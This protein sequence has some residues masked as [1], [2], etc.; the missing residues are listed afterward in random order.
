LAG[1][2]AVPGV[3]HPDVGGIRGVDSIPGTAICDDHITPDQTVGV[4]IVAAAAAGAPDVVVI[5]ARD[6]RPGEHREH[7]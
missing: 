1:V 3:D 7:R 6:R 2:R 5:G 4:G